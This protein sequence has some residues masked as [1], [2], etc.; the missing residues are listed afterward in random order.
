MR[1]KIDR[2]RVRKT[3]VFIP[4]SSWVANI[5]VVDCGAP[6]EHVHPVHVG[7]DLELWKPPVRVPRSIGEKLRILFVGGDFVRK[8]GS[9]LLDVFRHRLQGDAE[10]HL[11]TRQAPAELPPGVFVHADLGPND[12]RLA[13]L[14]GNSDLLVVPTTADVGPIWSFMEAM[15]M[16]LPIVGTDTGSN[17]EL[18]QHGVTGLVVKVG[19]GDGIAEAIRALAANTPLRLAMGDRG[20]SL[21]ETKYNAAKNVP[22]ILGV[23]KDA[24][25]R[26]RVSRRP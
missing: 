26:A 17:T 20:R 18:V 16:R 7:I 25:D 2:W 21:V 10:L 11:V 1:L 3:D 8:G 14:Y 6:R 13:D 4:F 5:L 19:D 24:V 23:M 12:K 22:Q 15:A 9:L